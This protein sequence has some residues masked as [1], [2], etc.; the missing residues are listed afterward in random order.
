MDDGNE[1]TVSLKDYPHPDIILDPSP[2]IGQTIRF[3]GMGAVKKADVLV[4]P[5]TQKGISGMKSS[6][7][8]YLKN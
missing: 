2:Y 6:T 7:F 3:T 8:N 1:L 5:I 4:M